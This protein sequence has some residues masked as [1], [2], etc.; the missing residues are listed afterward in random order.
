MMRRIVGDL[1]PTQVPGAAVHNTSTSVVRVLSKPASY[2]RP[3]T[4]GARRK[5]EHRH[6]GPSPNS[7]HQIGLVLFRGGIING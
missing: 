4:E 7:A 5:D 3:G 2:G 1:S 6:S